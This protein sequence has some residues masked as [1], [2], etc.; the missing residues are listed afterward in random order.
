MPTLCCAIVA[1]RVVVGVQVDAETRNDQVL[2]L[3]QLKTN[4]EAPFELFIA[5]PV[6]H[7][8]IGLPDY[9]PD[10]KLLNLGHPKTMARYLTSDSRLSLTSTVGET[11]V[12]AKPGAIHLLLKLPD[13][14]ASPYKLWSWDT[15]GLKMKVRALLL[16]GNLWL[17]TPYR[18]DQLVSELID[19]LK[20]GLVR[21]KR[22]T[23]PPTTLD[24][25][26]LRECGEP[27]GDWMT[28][29]HPHIELLEQGNPS[30]RAMYI[31]DEMRM[32]PSL[33]LSQYFADAPMAAS[34]PVLVRFPDINRERMFTPTPLTTNHAPGQPPSDISR[35]VQG[36]KSLAMAPFHA[37]KEATTK[38]HA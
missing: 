23:T 19:E 18:D 38:K 26:V 11:F 25:Y 24:L 22:C 28:W 32:N 16:G 14:G 35:V 31:R 5:T 21:S 2:R 17:E 15:R 3:I 8:T 12:T 4:V 33:T 1:T 29:E 13:H 27:H 6:G 37:V 7:T 34:I 10:Y 30:L 20:K 36:L 9:H